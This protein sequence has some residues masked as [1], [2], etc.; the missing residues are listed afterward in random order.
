MHC[1]VH[2][3]SE[4]K[5]A[6]V[7]NAATSAVFANAQDNIRGLEFAV[8]DVSLQSAILADELSSPS[9]SAIMQQCRLKRGM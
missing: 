4:Q 9:A 1:G 2:L 5:E 3:S 6:A 8:L 7:H